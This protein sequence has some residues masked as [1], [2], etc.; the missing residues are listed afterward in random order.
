MSL[1]KY[2]VNPANRWGRAMLAHTI[3]ANYYKMGVRNFLFTK[4][5]DGFDAT[6]VIF[7]YE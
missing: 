6:A 5:A 4:R 2:I 1:N 7:L 3:K